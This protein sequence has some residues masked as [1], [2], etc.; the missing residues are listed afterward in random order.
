MF[1]TSEEKNILT[2]RFPTEFP[3]TVRRT[4]AAFAFKI[5]TIDVFRTIPPMDLNNFYANLKVIK[6]NTSFNKS[7]LKIINVPL[8]HKK[9]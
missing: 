7:N 2:F 8:Q 3:R 4:F 6:S 1:K 9:T 5:G